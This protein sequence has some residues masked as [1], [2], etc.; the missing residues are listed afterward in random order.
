M[1]NGMIIVEKNYSKFSA[2]KDQQL[3]VEKCG[4]N[5]LMPT[6]VITPREASYE[7]TA[8]GLWG[9]GSRLIDRERF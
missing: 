8:N 9:L 3:S 2:A 7:I 5:I 4:L 6:D 1:F